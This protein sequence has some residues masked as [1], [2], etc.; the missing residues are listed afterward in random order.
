MNIIRKI[1]LILCVLGVAGWYVMPVSTIV[2]QIYGIAVL[3]ASV[4]IPYIFVRLLEGG[5]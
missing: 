5:K 1:A 4:V 3:M 2:E